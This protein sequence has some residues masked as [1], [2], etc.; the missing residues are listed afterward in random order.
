MIQVGDKIR[1]Y[2]AVHGV[3]QGKVSRLD[4]EEM[5]EFIEVGTGQNHRAHRKQ[6]KKLIPKPGKRTPM[7]RIRDLLEIQKQSA[8]SNTYMQGMFNGM[9]CIVACLEGRDP[10]YLDS[11]EVEKKSQA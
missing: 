2:S 4:G 6:C 10:N 9:E 3:S 11:S 7:D 1:C 5:L 8:K